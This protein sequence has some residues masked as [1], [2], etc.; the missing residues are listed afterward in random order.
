M[1]PILKE[2]SLSNVP[3]WMGYQVAI[4]ATRESKD[5]VEIPSIGLKGIGVYNGNTILGKGAIK[6]PPNFQ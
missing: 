1:T 4:D 6:T 5:W 2:A 3:L